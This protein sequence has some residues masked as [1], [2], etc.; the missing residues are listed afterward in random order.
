MNS[1]DVKTRIDRRGKTEHLDYVE[2][3]IPADKSVPQ[4]KKHIFHLGN[5]AAQLLLA[6]WPPLASHFYSLIFFLLKEPDVYDA[7]VEEVRGAF[8]DSHAINMDSVGN[9][10]YLHGGVQESLQLHQDTVDGLLRVSPGAVVDGEYIPQGVGF[11]APVKMWAMKLS[12][13]AVLIWIR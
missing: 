3:L 4:D 2:Q 12:L 6:S 13:Q 9:L 11:S 10:K 8:A 5:I 1:E 7:L